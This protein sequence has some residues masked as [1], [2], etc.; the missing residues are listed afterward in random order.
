[1][2]R[3]SGYP[4]ALRQCSRKGNDGPNRRASD[5]TGCGPGSVDARRLVFHRDDAVIGPRDED[6]RLFV[7][8]FFD[9]PKGFFTNGSPVTLNRYGRGSSNVE[10]NL[11]AVG[12]E[13]LINA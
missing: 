2:T 9:E 10:F 11:Q 12:D 7:Q 1:M 3:Q 13:R 4:L 6:V 8:F 5:R